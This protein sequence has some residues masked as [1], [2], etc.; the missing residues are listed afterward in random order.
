MR[1]K[2]HDL[3]GLLAAAVC[4]MALVA[5]ESPVPESDTTLPPGLGTAST[6]ASPNPTAPLPPLTATVSAEGTGG[7]DETATEPPGD[8]TTGHP[9]P[10]PTSTGG[11]PDSAG[12]SE[13]TASGGA[14]C[15]RVR[16]AVEPGETL[17]VRADPS[18]ANPIVGS[19]AP[20]AIVDVLAE[21]AGEEID[22]VALWYRV[23]TSALEGY[24]FSTFAVCTSEEPPDIDPNG[25]YLP[26][27]CGESA[28]VL[29][30]NNGAFSHQGFD[31][32]GFDLLLP[33]NT[34]VVAM[35]DGV[36]TH[37]FD[38]TQPGDPCYLGGGE[39]CSLAGNVVVMRHADGTLTHYLHLNQ[40]DV[41]VGDTVPVGAVVGLSGSTGFSSKPHLHFMRMT[42]CGAHY[43]QSIEMTLKDFGNEGIP[44]TGDTVTSG[45]C[46]SSL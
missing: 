26:L 4:T 36:V 33:S 27:S 2:R 30:G 1:P 6:T 44:Q 21:V 20:G 11:L 24:I 23:E 10:D 46:P 43:C 17:N 19:L 14:D 35:A 16:V 28:N 18:T 41:A 13:S 34:P 37:T 8:D 25:Y 31:L 12:D 15:P 22:G 9:R 40:V 42:D 3:Q 32:Y 45:N 29:Q 5:C 7:A 38:E 39:S